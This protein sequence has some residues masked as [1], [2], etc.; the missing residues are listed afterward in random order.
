[1][2]SFGILA[3]L[4]GILTAWKPLP[5]VAVAGGGLVILLAALTMQ[6]LRSRRS[7]ESLHVRSIVPFLLLCYVL[8]MFMLSRIYSLVGFKPLYLPDVLAILA[9]GI[10][11]F[12]A[13]WRHLGV[14][15][16]VSG[17]IAV[18]MLHATYVGH[19]HGYPSALKGLV[20]VIYPLIAVPI[21]GWLAQR[22]D[23]ERLLSVLPRFVFVLIPIGM[24][25]AHDHRIVPEAY[26]L[27]YAC[28]GSFAV[29]PGILGRKLLALSFLVGTVLLISYSAKR[30]VEITIGLSVAAAWFAARRP[31]AASRATGI[32]LA[33]GALV[34]VLAF[35]VVEGIIVVPPNIPLLSHIAKRA[36]DQQK[37]AAGDVVVRRLIWSYALST[38]WNEDPLLGVGAY[39]P[40]EVERG[41]FNAAAN[42]ATGV[43]DSYIGYTFYAGYPEGLLV[44]FVFV[45]GVVRLWRVRR[46]SPYAPAVL[47]CL[48]GAVLTATTNVALEL[49]YIGGPS[50][51]IL[52]LAF[53]LSAELMD[54]PDPP[55]EPDFSLA[56]TS[57]PAS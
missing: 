44:I 53:G 2:A 43:H 15:A 57:T 11:L 17:L 21:A 13:Q 31:R 51:L 6:A 35:S 36:S 55:E 56:L 24:V 1:M 10:A 41:S 25:I 27:E 8:P 9:A 16:L 45:W 26:G 14:Y 40:I 5:A 22:A 7:S 38:T 42:D 32:V 29:V 23:L 4:A 50:W 47:G 34:V 39:H 49:T 12:R 19:E 48:L 30:G 3:A 37:A 20:M 54:R 28:A 52:G 46:R 18:L 33:A